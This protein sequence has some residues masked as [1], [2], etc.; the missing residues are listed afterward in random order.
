MADYYSQCVV[1]PTLPLADL[2][3]AEQLLLRN[4]FDSELD[5]EG[6]YLFAEIGRN[7]MIDLE[8]P[9]ILAALTATGTASAATRLLSKAVADMA[10]GE[11]VAEIDLDDDW[12]EILQE[13]VAR[14]KTLTF[15]A[16]E[17]GFN[18]SKMRPDGFGGAAVV[19]TADAVDAMSTSQFID[20]TLAARLGDTASA[21]R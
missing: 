5:D 18:C 10:E 1:S 14:S 7:S 4:I 6:L 3:A 16:V 12:I 9:D 11:S 15:V 21:A 13:I 8:L 19:I 2:T 17:T 20:E